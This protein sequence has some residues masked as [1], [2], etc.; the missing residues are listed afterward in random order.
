MS[1]VNETLIRDVV[2]EVLGRLGGVPAAAKSTPA[3]AP[4]PAKADCGCG[5]KTS[6]ASPARRGNLGVFEDANEACAAAH[7]AFLQ[8]QK[9]GIAARVK[10]VEIVKNMAEANAETW[11]K[12]ELDE[13]KIGRLDHKIEK[14]KIIKLVPGVEFLGS[15]PVPKDRLPGGR[16]R[17]SR[18]DVQIRKFVI[19]NADQWQPLCEDVSIGEFEV[20]R[21]PVD[22]VGGRDKVR[23]HYLARVHGVRFGA[24]DRDA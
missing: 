9:A 22:L 17:Q 4:A 23:R 14:L 19:G 16:A 7:E 8:L 18:N 3:P 11:G 2:S 5:G 20:C 1:A 21:Q 15:G 6:S 13:T 10:I 24:R 12:L